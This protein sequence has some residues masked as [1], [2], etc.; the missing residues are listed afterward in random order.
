MVVTGLYWINMDI[1]MDE[2]GAIRIELGT[3]GQKYNI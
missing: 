3:T 1:P 2:Y